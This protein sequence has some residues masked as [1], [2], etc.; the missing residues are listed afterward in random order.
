MKAY[1]LVPDRFED[2]RHLAIREGLAA[3]GFDVLTDRPDPTTLTP[4]DQ[5]ILVT[6]NTYGNNAVLAKKFR[7]FVV[8]EEAYIRVIKGEKYFAIGHNGHNGNNINPIGP[9]LRFINWGLTWKA[10][11]EHGDHILV[12]G[13][14]G[15][16]YNAMAMQEDWPDKVFAKL[17]SITKRP[18]WFRPHPKRQRKMPGVTYDKLVDFQEPIEDQLKNCWAVVVFTSNSATNALLEGIP[19]FYEGPNIVT[20]EVSQKGLEAIE[21][22]TLGDRIQA[23]QRLSWSQFSM[24]EIKRGYPFELMFDGTEETSVSSS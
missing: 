3:F 1:C 14:R 24:D 17:R 19:A 5:D 22:P 18:L 6:W 15:F 4:N 7:N 16:G 23:F 21:K 10:W 11:R 9:P 20:R 8:C 12:C 13:Q 2:G